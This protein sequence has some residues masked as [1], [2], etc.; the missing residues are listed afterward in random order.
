MVA[1]KRMYYV[2]Q[3]KLNIC[4]ISDN[5]VLKSL[6]RWSELLRKLLAGTWQ[7]FEK[8]LFLVET[9]KK[10]K[11]L[12]MTKNWMVVWLF[13]ML[14]FRTFSVV[15]KCFVWNTVQCTVQNLLMFLCD[16]IVSTKYQCSISMFYCTIRY[17]YSR[18][19][20]NQKF[21]NWSRRK[22]NAVSLCK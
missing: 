18:S 11:N 4:I 17:V 20:L 14:Y 22:M 12:M 7:T 10:Q 13:C 9:L 21:K 1:T 6:L 5:Y 3:F 19:C 8:I 15:V 2:H 16:I